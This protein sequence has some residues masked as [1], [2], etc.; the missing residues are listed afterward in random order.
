[1]SINSGISNT[2]DGTDLVC[3]NCM[4]GAR[5]QLERKTRP[6]DLIKKLNNRDQLKIGFINIQSAL[7]KA[8]MIKDY[9][10]E[11]DFDVF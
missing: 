5:P 6:K 2:I 3:S 8:L 1:M 7:E 9:I 4:K 11:H 10:L